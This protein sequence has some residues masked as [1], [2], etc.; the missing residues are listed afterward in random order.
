MGRLDGGC[1]GG[2]GGGYLS[3]M[4]SCCRIGLEP[5]IDQA[6]VSGALAHRFHHQDPAMRCHYCCRYDYSHYASLLCHLHPSASHSHHRRSIP[7]H[8]SSRHYQA[9]PYPIRLRRQRCPRYSRLRGVR[10][11]GRSRRPRCSAGRGLGFRRF[12]GIWRRGW[13]CLF[14]GKNRAMWSVMEIVCREMR[15]GLFRRWCAERR[16]TTCFFCIPCFA[17]D[18]ACNA[19]KYWSCFQWWTNGS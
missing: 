12:R 17:G 8:T 10:R 19:T 18:D 1:C 5:S 11:L 6:A 2:G 4:R 13:A 14:V 16:L 15:F 7:D 3:L 9:Q